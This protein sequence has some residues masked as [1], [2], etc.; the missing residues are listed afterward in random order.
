MTFTQFQEWLLSHLTNEQNKFHSDTL[1]VQ[2]L[3][4]FNTWRPKQTAKMSSKAHIFE[5]RK[6]MCEMPT[7]MNR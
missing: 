5:E 6:Y 1:K 3:T 2:D 4:G 7:V